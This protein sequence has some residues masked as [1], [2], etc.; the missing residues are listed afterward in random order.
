MHMFRYVIQLNKCYQY[1]QSTRT[2]SY[3]KSAESVGERVEDGHLD[4]IASHNPH[5]ADELETVEYLDGVVA[6][7][8]V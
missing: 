5:H 1:R 7:L 2:Q 8:R 6:D 4:V 3:V